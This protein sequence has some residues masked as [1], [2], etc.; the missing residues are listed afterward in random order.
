MWCLTSLTN[1]IVTW[2]TKYH[3]LAVAA[4]RRGGRTTVP[5]GHRPSRRGRILGA[6]TPGSPTGRGGRRLRLV[7]WRRVVLRCRPSPDHLVQRTLHARHVDAGERGEVFWW[8]RTRPVPLDDV[9]DRHEPQNRD[10]QKQV[11]LPGVENVALA[12]S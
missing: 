3:G 5:G 11:L 9:P 6:G 8:V 4:R 7:G 12:P 10:G 2:T 1:A